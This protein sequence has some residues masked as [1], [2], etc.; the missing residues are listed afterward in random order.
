MDQS[1]P[2][3]MLRS[4]TTRIALLTPDKLARQIG[5]E[6][7]ECQTISKPQ[8]FTQAISKRLCRALEWT[9]SICSPRV[10]VVLGCGSTCH[11]ALRDL[12]RA[13]S[14]GCWRE[15]ARY[16]CER[17]EGPS[18]C[19]NLAAPYASDNGRLCEYIRRR[20]NQVRT[21]PRIAKHASQRCVVP[22]RNSGI[23]L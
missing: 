9:F 14:A 5:A 2:T 6:Q 17:P 7:G 12:I 16:E 19:R 10:S 20:P 22:C 8:R 18:S 21:P 11:R 3:S 4:P 1:T 13:P 23:S 15:A